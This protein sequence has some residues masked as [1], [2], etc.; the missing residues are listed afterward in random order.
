M[1][2]CRTCCDGSGNES[3]CQIAED[4]NIPYQ[5]MVSGAGHDAQVFGSYCPTCL[6]FVPSNGGISHS[7]KEFTSVGI[8][9]RESAF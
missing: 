9:K 6:L 3:P 7:P 2:G 4:K 8:W 5:D 1:D